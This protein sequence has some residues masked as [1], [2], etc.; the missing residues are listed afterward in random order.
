MKPTNIESSSINCAARQ[1]G[2]SEPMVA[3]A[4]TPS[5]ER[6]RRSVGMTPRSLQQHRRDRAT[7]SFQSSSS[8]GRRVR[9][10]VVARRCDGHDATRS[11]A[12]AGHTRI[13]NTVCRVPV[14]TMAT[15]R[16]ARG[17]H[18]R[19]PQGQRTAPSRT[20]GK[21]A[22]RNIEVARLSSVVADAG[23]LNVP[24]IRNNLAPG[25][26]GSDEFSTEVLR[27]RGCLTF[28]RAVAAGKRKTS[29]LS[30]A[31]TATGKSADFAGRSA[32]AQPNGCPRRARRV[33][34]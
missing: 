31:A 10:M 18:A 4:A 5:L 17:R 22:T 12:V 28:S 14:A 3:A 30:P 29:H 2:T 21:A 26:H 6:L 25:C 27:C 34:A 20:F 19:K 24:V 7:A 16:L 33:P 8:C 32:E 1:A 11:S 9:T 13:P 23:V 15:S